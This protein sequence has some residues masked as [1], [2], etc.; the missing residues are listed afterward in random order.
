MKFHRMR[1]PRGAVRFVEAPAA[2]A[3]A[4][5]LRIA[6]MLAV[7]HALSGVLAARDAP[8]RTDL[9]RAL[10]MTTA[11]L[12][13]LLDLLLLA[14]DIQ[15]EIAFLE[16]P[17]GTDPVPERA[18]RHVVRALAWPEQRA[19]WRVLLQHGGRG[20]RAR[21]WAGEPAARRVPSRPR[22]A[23]ACAPPTPPCSRS[24]AGRPPR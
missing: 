23:T 6:R 7:A 5:P 9:A 12:S 1:G 8:S 18:M 19:R 21:P 17:A 4:R 11:R 24:G 15:E 10:R 16:A 14:P 20:T 22:K 13:Q 3:E 2:K